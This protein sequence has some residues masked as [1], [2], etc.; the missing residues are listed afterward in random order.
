MDGANP[1]ATESHDFPPNY[2]SGYTPHLD[3]KERPS[4]DKSAL[5]LVHS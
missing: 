1:V 4:G 2:G 5:E 3:K